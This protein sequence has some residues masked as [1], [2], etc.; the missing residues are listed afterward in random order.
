VRAEAA[1]AEAEAVPSRA[2]VVS[3][4]IAIFRKL[5]LSIFDVT[6][7]ARKRRR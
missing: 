2:T 5:G 1:R 4:W 6:P 7:Y 3:A